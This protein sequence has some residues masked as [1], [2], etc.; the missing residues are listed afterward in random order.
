MSFAQWIPFLTSSDKL[1]YWRLFTGKTLFVQLDERWSFWPVAF[2]PSDVHLCFSC[3]N[4]VVKRSSDLRRDTMQRFC[5]NWQLAWFDTSL[6]PPYKWAFATYD[7]F[8]WSMSLFLAHTLTVT[9]FKDHI[10]VQSIKY[11]HIYIYIKTPLHEW[12]YVI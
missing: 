12:K 9:Y 4:F 1:F 11:T 6:F 8:W 3:C 10:L 2:V 7:S 5:L